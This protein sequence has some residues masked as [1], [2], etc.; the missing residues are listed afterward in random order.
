V[1]EII[2][3]LLDFVPETPELVDLINWPSIRG[4][5]QNWRI[6]PFENICVASGTGVKNLRL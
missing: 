6:Q 2:E 3:D 4:P 1:T 5:R